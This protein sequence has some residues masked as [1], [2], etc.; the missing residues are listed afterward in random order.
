MP[1]SIKIDKEQL[2]DMYMD[3]VDKVTEECE[4]KTNFG[5]EEIVN[6]I[7]LIIENNPQ[8]YSFQVKL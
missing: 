1:T 3:W 5:P 2:Y 4:W 6:E 8:L 7:C